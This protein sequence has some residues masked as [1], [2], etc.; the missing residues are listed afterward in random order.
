MKETIKSR[1]RLYRIWCNMKSRCCN[2]NTPKYK[3]YGGRGIRM[4]NFWKYSFEE[5]ARWAKENGYKDGLTIDRIDNNSGYC[6]MNCRWATPAQQSR[7]QRTNNKY[8]GICL[9][10]WSKTLKVERRALHNFIKRNGW[11]NAITFYTKKL[12]GEIARKNTCVPVCCVELN[13]IFPSIIDAAECMGLD[14]SNITKVCMG[15]R[16]QYKGNHWKYVNQQENKE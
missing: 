14:A 12:N 15:K 5:F 16:K 6:P 7:N 13:L 10:D 1:T 11:E 9:T 3:D 4:C 8:N 2:P